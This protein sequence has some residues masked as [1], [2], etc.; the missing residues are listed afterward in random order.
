[1]PVKILIVDP[2]TTNRIVLKVK[3]L[4]AFYEVLQAPGGQAARDALTT[5]APDLV[6]IGSGMA[7]EDAIDLVTKFPDLGGEGVRVPVLALLPGR[8][9]DTRRA[10]LTAG[11]DEVMER[12]VDDLILLARLR[13]LMRANQAM[14]ELALRDGTRR[15]LGLA[16]AP[17]GFEAPPRVSLAG[18]DTA[19]LTRLGTAL[20]RA[21]PGASVNSDLMASLQTGEAKAMPDVFVVTMSGGQSGEGLGLI[22]NIRARPEL[23]DAAI[24]AIVPPGTREA[25]AA[26]LDHGANDLVAS[27]VETAELVLRLRR[28]TARKRMNDRLRKTVQSGLHA[29]V[30]DPLTGL[31]NRRYAMPHLQRM[32]ER[33]RLSE[34]GFAVMI[35]D[36]DYFKRVNDEHGHAAGDAVLVETAERLLTNLRAVDLVARI[37]GEEFLIAMPDTDRD[38]AQRAADRLCH[39]IGDQPFVLPGPKVSISVTASIGVVLAQPNRADLPGGIDALIQAADRA[40][41]GSKMQGRNQFTLARNAA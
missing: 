1:M 28:L 23:R 37:G 2:V 6:L 33:C 24:L 26:A 25:A 10:L 35:A 38:A 30:T 40:L 22:S 18:H 29:A 39:V 5:Q 13:C 14:R 21:M 12:P 20:K 16:E 7:A 19:M 17:Q 41:Y 34:R 8:D 11:V 3:L 15:A 9:P 32:A 36:L 27:D 4:A 31:Y